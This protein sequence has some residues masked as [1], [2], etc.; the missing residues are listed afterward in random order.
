MLLSKGRFLA[1]LFKKSLKI[2]IFLLNFYQKFSDFSQ[3]Y[4]E[5]MYIV[6]TREK[7][8]HALLNILKNMLG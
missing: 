8:T 3:I 7:L 2:Q 5:F 1:K 6:Q 4:N